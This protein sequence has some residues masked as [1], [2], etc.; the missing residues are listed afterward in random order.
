MSKLD[1]YYRKFVLGRLY[2]QGWGTCKEL[3]KIVEYRRKCVS[4]RDECLQLVSDD[5]PVEIEKEYKFK[6]HTIY[7]GSFLSPFAH[8]LADFIPKEVQRAKFQIIIP[9]DF[10]PAPHKP[11]VIHYGGT[12]DQYYWRRRALVAKPLLFEYSMASIIL[13]NPFYGYRKP[14]D[15]DRSNLLHVKDLFLMGGCLVTETIVLL[16]W[17]ERLGYGPFILSGLSMGGHM[18]C[19]GATV[20]P[21]PVALVPCLSWTTASPTFTRGVMSSAISWKLLE[22]QYFSDKCYRHLKDEIKD[23]N[24]YYNQQR[25]P[26]QRFLLDRD[27]KLSY[28]KLMNFNTIEIK[29]NPV[30]MEILEFMHLLMDECTHMINFDVPVDTSLI[31]ILSAKDDA[32][33][34]RDGVSDFKSIWPGSEVEYFDLGHVGA[35]V[36]GQQKYRQSINQ[37]FKKLLE[38][39]HMNPDSLNPQN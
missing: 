33:V 37:T 11:V 25:P 18:A 2:S 8:K 16:K 27:S 21:K 7:D 35:F 26:E 39:Y 29:N 6:D 1:Q 14:K 32:Y 31:K 10:K 23:M 36:L 12:G 30:N 13:E 5:Y 28:E 4:K 9:K 3:S 24:H 19:L 15:Q 34:L 17:C 38:K 22:Q 20:W